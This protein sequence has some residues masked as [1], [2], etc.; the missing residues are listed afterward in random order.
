MNAWQQFYKALDDDDD[1]TIIS[2]VSSGS[3]GIDECGAEGSALINAANFGKDELLTRL[4]DLEA[5]VNLSME[6]CGVTALHAAA[7]QNLPETGRILIERGADVSIAAGTRVKS[8]FYY[9]PHCGETA[10]HL[11]AAYCDE[12]F[13]KLLLAA[14]ADRHAE[15]CVGAQPIDYLRRHRKSNR[16]IRSL[17]TI[18]QDWRP[19]AE[20][21]G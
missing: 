4:L 2:L 19:E 13:I 20:N 21:A 7:S 12:P 5:N 14:G 9:S 3:I 8:Q 16:D 11:A 10:L 1:D 15:D 18:I 17:K 6:D